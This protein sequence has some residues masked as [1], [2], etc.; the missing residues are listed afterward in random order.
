MIFQKK[1]L[2]EVVLLV[3]LKLLLDYSYVTYVYPTWNTSGFL[4]DVNIFKYIFAWLVYM[5]AIYVMY[6]KITLHISEVLLFIF[7]LYLLPNISYYA[8]S[9]QNTIYFLGLTLPFFIILLFI[10]NNEVVDFQISQTVHKLLLIIS[11]IIVVVVIGHYIYITKGD[12]VF[13]M[14]DVYTFRDLYDSQNYEGIFG[15]LNSWSSKILVVYLLAYGVSKKNY[16]LIIFSVVA[17]IS[18]Y[19]FSGHKMELLALIIVP[20]FYIYSKLDNKRIFLIV[21]FILLIAIGLVLFQYEKYSLLPS[22]VIRRALYLPA[23]L[24]YI[25]FD[26]FSEFG[27]IYWSNGIFKNF[28]EY[29][30]VVEPT[31]EVG[32]YLGHEN[33]V[34]NTGFLASGYMHLGYFGMLIYTF[35]VFVLFKFINTMSEKNTFMML[36]IL[37]LPI[38]VLFTSSDLLTTLLT[39]GLFISIVILY[40][41]NNVKK[42]IDE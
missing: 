10:K 29:P 17:I 42:Q 30:M 4:Y 27:H 32:Q 8:L 14:I 23:Y 13:N 7:L 35:M 9:N 40:I 16:F 6:L 24:N 28:I 12:Y 19:L 33:M 15:Y 11:L 1:T 38:Y 31:L 39:H 5:C 36:S 26:F 34:A 3:I 18:S 21:G 2:L 22:L 41:L 37:F 25:Y 20:F